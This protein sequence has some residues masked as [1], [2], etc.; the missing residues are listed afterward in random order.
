[1]FLLIASGCLAIVPATFALFTS[2]RS[3]SHHKAGQV[4]RF[5]GPFPSL[6]CR[7]NFYLRNNEQ[8]GPLAG[9]LLNEIAPFSG[10]AELY[11]GIEGTTNHFLP[12][13]LLQHLGH[14]IAHG[15]DFLPTGF[16][17]SIVILGL[18]LGP[19]GQLHRRYGIGTRHGLPDLLCRMGQYGGN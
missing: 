4:F 18:G 15:E 8:H 13:R 9:Q 11:P 19:I 17:L 14:L 10:W 1:M 5:N 6:A 3:N 16:Q 2:C 12:P 7:K